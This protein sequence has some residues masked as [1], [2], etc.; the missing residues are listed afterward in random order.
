MK[1]LNSKGVETRPG[2]YPLHSMKPYKKYERTIQYQQNW[3]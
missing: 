2:F 3:D 1:I